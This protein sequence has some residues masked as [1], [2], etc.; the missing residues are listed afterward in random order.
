MKV[1]KAAQPFEN[2]I[3][4]LII[5]FGSITIIIKALEYFNLI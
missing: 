3:K 5:I 1:P 2:I 4:W